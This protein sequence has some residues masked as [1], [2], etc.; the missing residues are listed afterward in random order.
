MYSSKMKYSAFMV[1]I[2]Y[3]GLWKALKIGL[4]IEWRTWRGDP[5]KNINSASLT[6]KEKESRIQAGPAILL[7][8]ILNRNLNESKALEYTGYIIE[9]SA[10]L[11]LSS[12]MGTLDLNL[13]SKMSKQ[14]RYQELQTKLDAFPNAH[15]NIDYAE[16]D[17]VKFSVSSC[18][19]VSLCH[20]VHLPQVAPLFCAV[21]HSYFSQKENRIKLERPTTLATGGQSCPF[22]LSIIESKEE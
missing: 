19:F 8:Q 5:F 18:H 15:F 13:L 10:H 14:E 7:F 6:Q 16:S 22:T 4:E 9:V 2:K 3:F 1:L 21:D 17:E 11:F 12:V 20:Q